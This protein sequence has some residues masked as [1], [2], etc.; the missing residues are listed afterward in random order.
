MNK[1]FAEQE[2]YG[3]IN[4]QDA[5]GVLLA[6]M[7]AFTAWCVIPRVRASRDASSN[8][9]RILLVISSVVAGLDCEA[10]RPA[11]VSGIWLV[12]CFAVVRD[13]VRRR[14]ELLPPG[15]AAG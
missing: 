6:V 10:G 11:T 7:V 12:A 14:S 13:A 1:A 5:Y 3:D 4:A 8:V 9:G 2:G 15:G